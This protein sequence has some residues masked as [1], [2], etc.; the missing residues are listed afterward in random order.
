MVHVYA[1][2]LNISDLHKVQDAIWAARAKWY[3]IGLRLGISADTL[4]AIDNAHQHKP[5]E[6]FTHTIKEWLRN[7]DPRPTWE[8]L[9]DALR[10][11]VVGHA[12]LAENLSK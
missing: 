1:G 4:D 2:V 9:A 3:D 11:P 8:A 12:H 6:C 7:D 10:S 5:E